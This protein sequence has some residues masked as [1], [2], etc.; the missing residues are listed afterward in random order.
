MERKTNKIKRIRGY[1]LVMVFAGLIIMYLGVFF[2]ETPWLFGLFILAGFIPLGFSVIIYF[3]VGMVSTRIITVECPNC[4][5]PTKFLGRVD[6]CYFCK[7]P[8]TIDKELE[9]EE[10]NLDY[11]VQHR[12]DAF[13]ARKKQ[14]E[15]Q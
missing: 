11:N 9:G 6:Y 8:L 3:W 13:V 7:E 2:R 4:E 5:R 10:F 14:K 15:D 12:R 1:A